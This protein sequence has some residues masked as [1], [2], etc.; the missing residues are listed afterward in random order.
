MV[1]DSIGATNPESN[2]FCDIKPLPDGSLV[3]ISGKQL[4]AVPGSG[5][6]IGA[7]VAYIEETDRTSGIRLDVSAS[8]LTASVGDLVK[9]AGVV[10][11]SAD[12]EVYIAVASIEKTVTAS[13]LKPIGMNN[14][15]LGGADFGAQLGVW[16]WRNIKK[17]DG[18]YERKL[19]QIGGA[20]N[21]GLFVKVWGK[22]T[23]IDPSGK[24]FYLNDGAKLDDGTKTGTIS[25]YGVWV[26][27]SGVAYKEGDFLIM[28]AISS[29]YKHS[30]GKLRRALLPINIERL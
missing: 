18:T 19:L 12:G 24:Y 21:I 25:N 23:Q 9:L 10:H 14:R 17:P 6:G 4:T 15:N 2:K 11:T 20:A 5:P 27:A 1:V 26:Q 30:D 29:C 28:T 7:G 3:S 13:R 22:V 8:S 16:D